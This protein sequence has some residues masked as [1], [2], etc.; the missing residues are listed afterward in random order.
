MFNPLS[1]ET[2]ANVTGSDSS[3]GA[4]DADEE[5]PMAVPPRDYDLAG[6]IERT[7]GNASSTCEC[8][9]DVVDGH[10]LDDFIICELSRIDFSD[11]NLALVCRECHRYK[12]WEPRVRQNRHDQQINSRLDRAIHWVSQDPIETLFLRR[13]ATGSALLLTATALTTTMTAF[14]SGLGPVWDY[15]GTTDFAIVGM[16]GL[17]GVAAGYW[18]HLHEREENDHRGTHIRE[19]NFSDRPWSV[20]V[21]TTAGIALSTTIIILS[22]NTACQSSAFLATLE[23]P[24]SHSNTSNPLSEP[25]AVTGA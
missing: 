12:D 16:I 7:V 19:C 4:G 17:L 3:D 23:V 15:L 8:C 9:G 13:A 6:A 24:S 1:T 22:P 14:A 2:S 25:T 21:V 11:E 18:L 10:D 20:L 5:L